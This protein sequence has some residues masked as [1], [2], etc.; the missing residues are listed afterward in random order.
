MVDPTTG[1]RIVARVW[2]REE[3]FAGPAEAL[4]PDLTL[5]L[6]DG[7]LVSILAAGVPYARRAEVSGTHRPEGIFLARGPAFRTSARVAQFPI[8]DVAPLLLHGLGLPVPEEQDGRVPLAALDP[9]WLDR[10]PVRSERG[11]RARSNPPAEAPRDTPLYSAE[12]ERILAERLR[13][14]GYID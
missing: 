6:M 7:G 8:V 9:G 10:H 3:I 2:R 1:E 4:A 14:L 12:D 11:G 13:A 5:E